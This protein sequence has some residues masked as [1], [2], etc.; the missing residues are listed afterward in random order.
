MNKLYTLVSS[1]LLVNFI[2]IGCNEV[3][4]TTVSNPIPVNETDDKN[5]TTQEGSREDEESS[6]VIDEKD[7][8]EEEDKNEDNT[9][10]EEETSS[11]EEVEED[12]CSPISKSELI[13]STQS[14]DDSLDLSIALLN[15]SMNIL[16]LS[17]S[18]VASGELTNL[19]YVRGMLEVSQDINRMAKKI[20]EMADKILIMSDKIGDM[21]D[22]ILETEKNI[23]KNVLLTEKN[24]LEAQKNFNL[25]NS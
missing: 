16:T 14:L 18:L 21:A 19:S 22:R 17:K 7:N 4:Q 8:K 3:V 2:F 9:T 25:L 10:Q 5:E 24:I 20:G 13:A 12:Y 11:S 15:N 23:S 6:N 1:L